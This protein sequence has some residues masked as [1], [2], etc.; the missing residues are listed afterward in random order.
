MK[1]RLMPCALEHGK[2]DTTAM[3]ARPPPSKSSEH[4]A[5]VSSKVEV[6]ACTFS[7]DFDRVEGEVVVDSMVTPLDHQTLGR[8]DTNIA[9]H[10]TTISKVT[11]LSSIKP[12]AYN[13]DLNHAASSGPHRLLHC[14]LPNCTGNLRLSGYF[15]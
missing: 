8:L 13:L 9:L 7:R 15:E 4:D 6:V 3:S 2:Q 1:A 12:E 5:L 14:L 11:V 10:C